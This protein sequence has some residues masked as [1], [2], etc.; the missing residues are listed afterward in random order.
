M[1]TAA[2]F[3]YASF[4]AVENPPFGAHALPVKPLGD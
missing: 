2:A 4:A 1:A 3:R